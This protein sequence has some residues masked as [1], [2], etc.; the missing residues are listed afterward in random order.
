M[1]DKFVK[2]YAVDVLCDSQ[3]NIAYRI[4]LI[5]KIGEARLNSVPNVR[6]ELCDDVVIVAQDLITPDKGQKLGLAHLRNLAT[7]LHFISQLGFVH[8]DINRRNVCATSTS[9]AVLDFEPCL[10]QRIGNRIQFKVTLPYL[11][12]KDREKNNVSSLTDKL[13]FYYFVRRFTGSFGPRDIVQLSRTRNHA[14]YLGF[15]E[16]ELN[17]KTFQELVDDGLSHTLTP[18][19]D[20]DPASP[21]PRK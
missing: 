8:G 12:N 17:H 9:F 13:G 6:A 7:D 18:K 14:A 19:S 1:K 5:N 4:E 10:R 21:S 11:S 2:K 16:D 15:P 20:P 3:A